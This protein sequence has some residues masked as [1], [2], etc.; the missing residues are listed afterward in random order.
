MSKQLSGIFGYTFLRRILFAFLLISAAIPLYEHFFA[1]PKFRQQLIANTEAQ[2]IRVGKHLSSYD[3]FRDSSLDSPDSIPQEW[4]T[5]VSMVSKDLGLEKVKVFAKNGEVIFSTAATDIGN[6]NKNDYFVNIVAKNRVFTKIAVKNGRTME[7]RTVDRSVVETYVPITH[8]DKFMGSF[9]IY[10]DITD[11]YHSMDDLLARL[12]LDVIFMGLGLSILAIILVSLVAKE[13]QGRELAQESMRLS[14]ERLRSMMTTALDAIISINAKGDIVEFNP[15][16]EQLFGFSNSEAIGRDIAE[17][18]IPPDLRERHR[19]GLARYISSGTPTV[20]R[21]RL[22]LPALRADGT[23]IDTGIVITPNMMGGEQLFTAFLRDITERKQMLKSMNEAFT[24]LEDTNSRLNVEMAERKLIAEALAASERQYRSILENTAEGFWLFS[25]KNFKILEVNKALCKM[26]GATAEDIIGKTPMD[27]S[28]PDFR[29]DLEEVGRQIGDSDHRIFDTAFT[30][31]AGDDLYATVHCTT[32]KNAAGAAETAFAFITDV[33]QRRKTELSLSESEE[34]FRSV[35]SSI[36]DAIIATDE[37]SNII[38][39]NHG[40]EMIFGYSESE[41]LGRS[42]S[43][44]IPQRYETA[45]NIGFNRVLQSGKTRLIGKMVEFSGVKKSGEEFPLEMALNRWETN[46]R[47]F[48]SAVIRDITARKLEEKKMERMLHSEAAINTLIQSATKVL[49]LSQQLDIALDLILSGTWI[50]TAEQ[51]AVFL[52]D[53]ETG[54]LEM[55]AQKGLQDQ[56]LTPCQRVKPGVCLCGRVLETKELVFAGGIDDRHLQGQTS[57]RHQHVSSG[58]TRPHSG[59]GG[60]SS[61]RGQLPVRDHR[62]H[63]DG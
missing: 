39:W 40:A 24:S 7:G 55:A 57:R 13:M 36:S 6:I 53:E 17:T 44:L 63:Q 12:S 48:F 45:H 1:F 59:R 8:D 14:E 27:Y 52:V 28:H 5:E 23:L 41:V 37:G 16:A 58:W 18:I 62:A 56:I 3:F 31:R 10:F 49:S 54:E 34:R 42:I 50:T 43:I 47:Q 21:T 20:M 29:K 46:G 35:T 26:L 32:V 19:Q 51:G 22:E 4:I 38:F 9:E 11:Q 25:A 30:T 33:T 2:A 15:A 60:V 61:L